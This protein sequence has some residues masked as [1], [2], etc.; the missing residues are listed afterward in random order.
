[1][2]GY[3]MMLGA[4]VSTDRGKNGRADLLIGK[5]NEN[6][7]RQIFIHNQSERV[8]VEIQDRDTDS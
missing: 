3:K 2:L 8:P 1:V 4:K 7:R 6:V 5:L